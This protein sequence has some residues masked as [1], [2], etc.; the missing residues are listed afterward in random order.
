MSEQ[1]PQ[2]HH[3]LLSREEFK[4][5]AATVGATSYLGGSLFNALGRAQL[6]LSVRRR[7]SEDIMYHEITRGAE[8]PE[9][10]ISIPNLRLHLHDI[11]DAGAIRGK[12]PV[13]ASLLVEKLLPDDGFDL[14]VS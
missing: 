14:G 9:Y 12:Q 7:S 2:Q 11:I 3:P 10:T 4:S 6:E 5:E 13:T 1:H 8:S